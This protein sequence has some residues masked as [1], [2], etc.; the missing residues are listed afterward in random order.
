MGL[1]LAMSEVEALFGRAY[2]T[3]LGQIIAVE[4]GLCC[5]Y[6]AYCGISGVMLGV[7]AMLEVW[8]AHEMKVIFVAMGFPQFDSNVW[9]VVAWYT[10]LI[11]M[12]MRMMAKKKYMT[13]LSLLSSA[14]GGALVTVSTF[15]FLTITAPK[16]CPGLHYVKA[17]V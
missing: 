11:L 5:A 8:L 2:P 6:T 16:Y 7:G 14:M 10:V 17:P 13:V 3:L 9:L 12:A 1:L 4:A 15:R